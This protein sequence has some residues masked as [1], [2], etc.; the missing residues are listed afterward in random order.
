MSATRDTVR[1][2]DHTGDGDQGNRDGAAASR[3]VLVGVSL[4]VLLLV[5]LAGESAARPR[6]GDRGWAPGSLPWEPSPAGVTVLLATAYVL[7]VVA[8]GLGLWRPPTRSWSWPP[9]LGLGVLAL[10]TAPFGSAD[11]TNYAAYGRIAVLGG[12][13]YLTAPVDFAGGADPVAGAVEPPWSDTTSVYGPF[14]TLVQALTSVLGGESMRQ[15]VWVWQVVVVLCWLGTRWLLLRAG[16][17]RGR[18][19]VLWTAN[20]LVFGVAVLGAHVDLL[21]IALA[22]A[23]LV[24]LSR[25]PLLAGVLA[26]LALSTKIT[27][28]VVLLGLVLTA[29]G[30]RA[31]TRLAQL[32][33]GAA[34]PTLAL[35]AW[36]GPHVNDQLERARDAVALVSP[37]KPLLQVAHDAFTA[38]DARRSI[39]WLSAVVCVLLAVLLWRA[40]SGLLDDTPIGVATR[41]SLVLTAAYAMGASYSLPW[42]DAT[43]FALLPLARASALDTVLLLRSAVMALAY[44]PGRVVGLTPGVERLTLQFRSQ[45]GPYAGVLAWVVTTA[46]AVRRSGGGAGRTNG[47]DPVVL[48]QITGGADVKSGGGEPGSRLSTAPRPPAS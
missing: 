41:V 4:A 35:Y 8:V 46:V 32:L 34:V 5:G 21:A 43:V 44:V 22:L 25:S 1:P 2:A 36:A 14:A 11:H 38:D 30:A 7:G 33:I 28:G 29:W 26:G 3:L 31:W 27:L 39:F 10:L 15:T 6:L 17:A 13:P 47:P 9:V 42:Y 18:V 48:Q 37:L 24:L 12:D 19:D 23:A 45:I 20:P 16:A 40:T